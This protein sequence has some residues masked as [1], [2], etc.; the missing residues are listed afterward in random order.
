ML[1][2]LYYSIKT[3]LDKKYPNYPYSIG[4]IVIFPITIQDYL[5]AFNINFFNYINSLYIGSIL[6]LSYSINL[7]LKQ[8]FVYKRT[9]N[10]EK[11]Y[12]ERLEK[13]V[14][15]KT[16]KLSQ[17]NYA[18]V[19]ADNLKA[20]LFSI[21]SHDL[22]SPLNSLK[23]IMYLFRNQKLSHTQLK[24]HILEL[25]ETIEQ[26]QF[27]LESLLIWSKE[28]IQLDS[29]SIENINLSQL[30]MNIYDMMMSSAAK[31]SIQF[32][33]VMKDYNYYVACNENALNMVIINL[34]TNSIKFTQF[35]GKVEFGIKSK[36]KYF[37]VYV[38]DN[39][40]G[41]EPE[42]VKLIKQG[43]SIGSSLGT[44]NER[45]SGIGLKLC[46]EILQKLDISLYAISKP[47][48]GSVFYFKLNILK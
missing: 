1:Q 36:P 17:T 32:D 3:I 12:S 45:G 41:I 42:D 19:Q 23:Q 34:I 5:I 18:L 30:L 33:L 21:I 39:G 8:H 25:S 4:L 46:Q 13:E 15:S 29:V 9:I 28:Q 37:I 14:E 16:L 35:E 2:S 27:M 7:I 6:V 47:G 10:I 22:R 38:K 43:K 44:N 40:I 20:R 26:N 48:R 31:K 24:E 11:E